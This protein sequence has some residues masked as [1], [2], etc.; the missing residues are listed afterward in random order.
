MRRKV[1]LF[2][3]LL[4]LA[5]FT[6]GCGDKAESTTES[7]EAVTEATTE[8]T[9]ELTTE[10]VT[11]EEP[12][13]TI[14]KQET[15]AYEIQISNG[16][17]KAIQEILIKNSEDEEY[18]ENLL[19]ENDKFALN[20]ER[21]LYYKDV[22]SENKEYDIKIVFKNGDSYELH[23]LP[24]EDFTTCK[25]CLED[26]VAFVTYESINDKAVVST[27]DAEIALAEKANAGGSGDYSY[28]TLPLPAG[29]YPVTEAPTTEASTT[30]A[31]APLPS[32][33]T[34]VTEAPTT[35]APATEGCLDDGLFY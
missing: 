23:A 21:I 27:K 7:T 30:E 32:T 33:E 10:E 18:S 4:G 25:L 35:Q 29:E 26:E 20:E 3:G 28:T 16:T 9:T 12:V 8:S 17:G 31:V 19:E 24:F 34:P 14:G 5:V 11:T 13:K 22:T 2:A 6:I 1:F 15:G